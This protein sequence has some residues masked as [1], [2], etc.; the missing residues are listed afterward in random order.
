MARLC[1]KCLVERPEG[2]FYEPRWCYHCQ[3]KTKINRVNDIKV[4]RKRCRFCGNSLDGFRRVYCG[5]ECAEKAKR[6][7]DAAR[8]ERHMTLDKVYW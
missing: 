8:W 2:D 3:Y 6:G 4:V 1:Q 5:D 7:M